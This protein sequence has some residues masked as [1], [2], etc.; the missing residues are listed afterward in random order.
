M[1]INGDIFTGKSGFSGE[2]GHFN[3]FEIMRFFVIVVSVDVWNG[4]FW[5]CFASELVQCVQDGKQS[6]LSKRILH[7]DTSFDIR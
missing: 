3:V 1:V 4:G 6:I 2:F 7:G 5:S